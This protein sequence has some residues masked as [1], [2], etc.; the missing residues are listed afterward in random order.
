MA[1]LDWKYMDWLYGANGERM[2]R[3][4]VVRKR[5]VTGGEIFA[6]EGDD[7]RE[8]YETERRTVMGK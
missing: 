7:Y 5:D 8:W 1:R 3:E 2:V 4:D 6:D